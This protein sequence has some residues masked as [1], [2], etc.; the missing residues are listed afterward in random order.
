MKSVVDVATMRALDEATVR[1]M[2]PARDLMERAGKA[3]FES[4]AWRGPV[5]IV[6]GSGNNAGDGYALAIQL[7]KHDVPCRLV[8]LDAHFSEEGAY[9]YHRAMALGVE[10]VLYSPSV[11]FADDAEIVDCIFGMGFHGTVTGTAKQAIEAINAAGKWVLS[12]DINSGLNGD[13]GLGETCVRSSL[14]V[15]IQ[16]LKAGHFLGDAK[17]VIGALRCA[18]IGILP[19]KHPMELVEKEDFRS[20]LPLRKHNGHKGIYGYVTILGGCVAYSG[21]AKLANLSCA[22]LRSGCGVAK[23]MVP[24]SLRDAVLPYLLESTLAL[25]PEEHGA[26]RYDEAFLREQ[27]AG[28]R[29]VAIGMGWGRAPANERILRYLL[30][31]TTCALLIDADGL[32]TLS[33]MEDG[34]ALLQKNKGRVLLTPHVKEFERLSGF[35]VADTLKH[36]TERAKEYAKRCG[37]CVL[38]KGA[39]TVVTDGDEVLLVDRGCGGMST[40]GSGDVLSGVLVGLLGF[41]PLCPMTAALG[42]YLA[43]R[44]GELAQEEKG[45]FGMLASDTVAKLPDALLELERA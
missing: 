17:D 26:V 8:R 12:A 9:F 19:P 27:L 22:A 24:A 4:H 33:E 13:N 43:G 5:A 1:D 29:A 3:L 10:D 41:L 6:C 39:C 23:L 28:Q 36:P 7:Q 44:A 35:S 38:L 14:T 37:A 2:L 34:E 11:S 15:A 30:T 42:A 20:F 18:D 21:A 40:A 31:A 32:N 25:L 16:H 45:A